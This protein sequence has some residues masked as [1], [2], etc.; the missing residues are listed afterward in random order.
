MK[1]YRLSLIL[2]LLSAGAHAQTLHGCLNRQSGQRI[3]LPVQGGQYIEA[4]IQFD[5]VDFARAGID[6][7]YHVGGSLKRRLFRNQVQAQ[8]FLLWQPEHT[9]HQIVL[10][11]PE[12]P[13]LCYTLTLKTRRAA[14]QAHTQHRPDPPQSPRLQTVL[15]AADRRLAAQQFWQNLPHTPLS[16]I[17]PDGSLLLTFLYRGA[18]HNVRL[19]GAPGND[20]E[21]LDR[22]PETDIW[23]KSFTVPKNLVLSY[24]L[25]PDVPTP[26]TAA[27]DPDAAYRK[28]RA[29]LSVIQ[30]DPLNPQHYGTQSLYSTEALPQDKPQGSL[31]Q[32]AFRSGILNNTRRIWIYRNRSNSQTEPVFVYLFDGQNYLDDTRL[33]AQL[34]RLPETMPPVYL[35]LIDNHNRRLELPGHAPFA[36]ML[37]RELIPFVAEKSGIA[38][39]PQRSV[40]SGSSYGGLAAAYVAHRYPQA[41]QYIVPMSGSFWWRPENNP[42]HGGIAEFFRKQPTAPLNWHISAGQYETARG[43]SAD[44][45]WETGRQLAGVLR[46]QGHQVRFETTP[47]GHDYA[48]WEQILPKALRG[49]FDGSASRPGAQP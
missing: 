21:W 22:L 15:Q 2:L 11:A 28:R 46:A 41:F 48:V 45:I 13:R 12:Q 6:A 37:V 19:I 23:Y 10:R 29:L 1:K 26:E 42:S 47:G 18:Q 17:L 35:V 4:H 27:N 9:A 24:Q 40:L 43:H 7:D 44:G 49:F 34:D 30:A 25:A 16:E 36:D 14:V 39:N 32:Y 20:H 38:H 5:H 8:D 3:G 33:L 31:K